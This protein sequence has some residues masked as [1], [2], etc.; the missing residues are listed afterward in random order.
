MK[1]GEIF[2]I[3]YYNKLV[4]GT[5]R[6]ALIRKIPRTYRKWEKVKEDDFSPE[7]KTCKWPPKHRSQS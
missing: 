2:T 3:P 6:K 1:L 4:S 7:N 5:W